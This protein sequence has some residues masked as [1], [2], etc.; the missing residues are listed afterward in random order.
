MKHFKSFVAANWHAVPS[1]RAA[2]TFNVNTKTVDPCDEALLDLNFLLEWIDTLP[3]P[4]LLMINAGLGVAR[5]MAEAN[6]WHRSYKS[7]SDL[8]RKNG[9][10]F[11]FLNP[12]RRIQEWTPHQPFIHL[13]AGQGSFSGL[14]RKAESTLFRA[15]ENDLNLKPVFILSGVPGC[16][17]GPSRNVWATLPGLLRDDDVGIWPF[18]GDFDA[19]ASNYKVVL[20]EAHP[21]LA[22]NLSLSKTLPCT[23]RTQRKRDDRWRDNKLS[24]IM[25]QP[26]FSDAGLIF[27]DQADA[28]EN[29]S[30]FDALMILLASIRLSSSAFLATTDAWEGAIFGA[31]LIS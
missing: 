30:S 19:C 8:L 18:D 11:D 28:R 22:F 20:C 3:Q 27:M 29:D 4:C 24:D 7:F 15:F 2:W 26:W 6:D 5:G 25:L 16:V 21:R 31:E 13:P 23:L 10:T 12:V 14:K 1:Q 9:L 17:G